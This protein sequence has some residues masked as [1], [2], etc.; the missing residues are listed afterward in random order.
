MHKNSVSYRILL[1]ILLTIPF[2]SDAFGQARS[3]KKNP[4]LP[5]ISIGVAS[6]FYTRRFEHK[7]VSPKP[8]NADDLSGRSYS[9]GV[10]RKHRSKQRSIGFL[11]HTFSSRAEYSYDDTFSTTDST[12]ALITSVKNRRTHWYLGIPI[13]WSVLKKK[14]HS[15]FY[16]GITCEPMIL[17]TSYLN[18]QRENNF[19]KSIELDYSRNLSA[20]GVMAA[21]SVGYNIPL[22]KQKSIRI[23]LNNQ[24]QPFS[25][26][27]LSR[28]NQHRHNAEIGLMFSY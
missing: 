23:T 12:Y 5:Y 1:I 3:T 13:T 7:N 18:E 4:F 11:I 28:L 22:S 8:E 17:L 24:L 20:L 6:N 19:E 15:R 9:F 16:M 27:N 25:Y 21:F 10:L 2:H 26:L 14:K